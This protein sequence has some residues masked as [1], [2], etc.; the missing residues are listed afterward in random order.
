MRLAPGAPGSAAAVRSGPVPPQPREPRSRGTALARHGHA[1]ERRAPRLR[2][3]D[4]QVRRRGSWPV[5]GGARRSPWRLIL[6]LLSP[7]LLS[8]PASCAT[9][10]TRRGS[11]RPRCSETGGP[12]RSAGS[13]AR[14]WL[15]KLCLPSSP[16]TAERS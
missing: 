9:S 7:A 1:A 16:E 4:Q 3:Q 14:T 15:N 12:T 10:P 2:A 5:R 13:R 11:R 6:V 8:G